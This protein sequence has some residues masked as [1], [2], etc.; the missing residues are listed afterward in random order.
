M[1]EIKGKHN[2]ALVFTENIEATAINQIEILCNQEF[3]KNCKIRIMPDVHTGVGCTIG[4]TMTVTDK[5]VPNL[6]GVDIGCGMEVIRLENRQIDLL[7][8]DQLIYDKIPYGFQI[9]NKAH[10][11]NDKIDLSTLKCQAKVDLARA[12]RSI[13]S[14]GGGNHFIE[15]N[16]DSHD[17]L[18]IVVH[19][20][21]RHLG[22]E[23][24]SLYQEMAFQLLKENSI[25]VAGRKNKIQKERN[26]RENIGVPKALAYLTGEHFQDYIHDMKIVQRFAELNRKAIL[27]EIVTGMKLTVAEQFTTI[28]N[29]ID[30]DNMIL[31]KGAVSAKKSEKLLIPIN[32]RDGSLICVGK[33]N[34]EWNFSAPHG[35]GRIMSRMQAKQS[36]TLAQYQ[37]IMKGIFTTSVNKAILDECP[38]A[39]KPMEDII[40]NIG[41]TVDVIDRIQ[42][43]YNFKAA[44]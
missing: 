31:R 36:F 7:K 15:V 13:G 41:D 37:E 25:A 23:V 8:L 17:N 14:L 32:M 9:R 30:T 16:K 35:A 4:T 22:H 18:Y 5:V 29:Y 33:G 2:T 12:K 27:D 43:I 40:K 6:V 1:L 39:Y 11:Y 44:E 10:K 24:A 42:P 34:P 21:S 3:A 26:K 19:S 20:G 38:L 28:H